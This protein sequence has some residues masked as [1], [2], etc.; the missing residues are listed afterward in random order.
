MHIK[1]HALLGSAS[2]TRRHITSLHFGQGPRRALFQASLHADEVPA[3][4]VAQHLRRRLSE[5][6]AAGRLRGEIVL[7]PACNPIGLGQQLWGRH[8]GR[9][10]VNSGHNFNRHYPDLVEAAIA[11]AE[12]GADGPANAAMLRRAMQQALAE[13]RPRSELES[14]RHILLDLA[15]GAEIVLDLHCDNEGVMHLYSTPEQSAMA[16]QLGRCMQASLCLVANESGDFPFDEAC[17]TSWPRLQQHYAARHPV[18]L[19]CFAATV[20]HR[21]VC[22]VSHELAAQDTEGLLRFL[23]LQGL[24][25]GLDEPVPFECSLR[26]LAGSMPVPAPHAGVVVYTRA[27]GGEVRAGEVLAELI[28][29]VSGESTPLRAPIDGLYYRREQQ[30]WVQAGQTVVQLAGAQALRQ[31]KL[32]SA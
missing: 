19:G 17:S 4:L 25:A 13:R 29:P 16:G 20:E 21:G 8:Q 10:D 31:G 27:L 24:I 23:G 9:F 18:P 22:D 7:I 32:L 15:L 28:E 5:L 11:R 12:L 26:P 6:E 30:R 2:G 14:L 3:M 1:E